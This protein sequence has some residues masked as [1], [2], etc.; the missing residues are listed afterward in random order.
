MLNANVI[1]TAVFLLAYMNSGAQ[2]L[3]ESRLTH[4]SVNQTSELQGRSSDTLG[5]SVSIH[6][7]G[8]IENQ[9]LISNIAIDKLVKSVNERLLYNFNPENDLSIFFGQ[10]VDQLPR[11]SICADTISSASK[12]KTYPSKAYRS[13]DTT[14][15]RLAYVDPCKYMSTAIAIPKSINIW[16][17]DLPEVGHGFASYPEFREKC[18][19]IVMN[20]KLLVDPKDPQLEIAS[21]VLIHEIGHYF[22][23]EHVWSTSCGDDGISDTNL[24]IEPSI[25]C[26]YDNTSYSC[27]SVDMNGNFM[28]Y[29]FDCATYFTNKQLSRIV[30]GLNSL[31]VNLKQERCNF[32]TETSSSIKTCLVITK[33]K[34]T[35]RLSN[36]CGPTNI[37]I[38]TINGALITD[39][40]LGLESNYDL[41]QLN[42]SHGVYVIRTGF[43]SMLFSI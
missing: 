31:D 24:Q 23:L 29:S 35:V 28:N 18:N 36:V 25:G 21:G 2:C 17:L 41:S 10:D 12:L 32:N 6:L 20:S 30:D 37:A 38:Y 13:T 42:L 1:L 11:L 5:I 14:G 33:V 27:S 7:I 4:M 40:A 9:M 39:I 34:S 3:V 43:Y 19:G 22:G 16:F 8:S 15:T 26:S